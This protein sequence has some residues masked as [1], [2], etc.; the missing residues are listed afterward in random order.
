MFFFFFLIGDKSFIE[1]KVHHVH[2]DEH[3][4]LEKITDTSRN[5]NK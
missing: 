3:Y 4:I 1:G 2:N 5:G